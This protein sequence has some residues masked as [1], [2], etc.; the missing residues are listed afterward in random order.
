MT[1]TE[2]DN[3]GA[4]I[5]VGAGGPPTRSAWVAAALAVTFYCA[6]VPLILAGH[7]RGR[8]AVDQ[9]DYHV[10]VI[11]AFAR[12]W[13]HFDFSNYASATT[14]GYHVVLAAADRWLGDDLRVL[15]LTGSVFCAGLLVTMGMA[16]AR[17][18]N[19]WQAL[20]LCL[21]VACSLYVFSSGAYVLPDDAA[22]WG[23]LACLLVALR[24]RWTFQTFAAAGALLLAVVL[25]R[26]IH[27]WLAGVFL[28]R[29][30]AGAGDVAVAAHHFVRARPLGS[31]VRRLIPAALGPTR[32]HAARTRARGGGAGVVHAA[33]ARDDAADVPGRLGCPTGL[34]RGRR[35]FGAAAA[36]SGRF[37]LGIPGS[38][39]EHRGVIRPLFLPFFLPRHDHRTDAGHVPSGWWAA[40]VGGLLGLLVGV[41][42]LTAY[43]K[44]AGRW[45]GLWNLTQ[46]LPTF[47]GHSPLIWALSA[48][49]GAVLAMAL[50]A[51]DAAT[52]G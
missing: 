14:P 8:A 42:P 51:L 22:W 33:L 40:A 15:R 45:S 46:H 3:A 16:V 18:V 24:R 32:G 26:Q 37:E 5:P 7:N 49:G 30:V 6:A 2:T 4:A 13:P 1:H 28:R 11:R 25:V 20:A 35:R 27:V 50:A 44:A 38:D 29:G 36:G 19:G 9:N 41:V 10:P 12:Q 21:P 23:V 39:P 52:G 17:R 48:L 43:D 34:D 31:T 47:L